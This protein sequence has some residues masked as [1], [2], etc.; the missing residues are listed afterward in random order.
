MPIPSIPKTLLAQKKIIPP[1][2][3][4]SRTALKVEYLG[5]FKVKFK[6]ASDYDSKNLADRFMKKKPEFK[7]SR[8]CLFND[9]ILSP[10]VPKI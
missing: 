6:A 5:E 2:G 4:S 7:I 1:S 9:V 8:C 10:S 3:P